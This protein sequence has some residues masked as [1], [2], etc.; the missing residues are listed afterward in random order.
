LDGPAGSTAFGRVAAFGSR[1]DEALLSDELIKLVEFVALSPDFAD[2][3]GI[4]PDLT[5]P[6]SSGAIFTPPS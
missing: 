5:T 6:L 3:V 1:N 4:S 2:G